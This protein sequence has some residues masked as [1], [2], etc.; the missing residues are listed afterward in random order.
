[1]SFA[2]RETSTYGGAPYE[3]YLFQAGPESWA[4]TSGD[5]AREHLGRTYLPLAIKRTAIEQN[6]ES[7]SGEIQVVLPRTQDLAQRFI[8][9]LPVAPVSLVIF[10]GHDG[11]PDVVVNFTG[12]VSSAEYTGDC[13]LHVS[14]EAGL[15]R[16]RIPTQRFQNQC[17]W[18]VYSPN[19]CGVDKAL[20]QVSATLTF[21]DGA[22]IKGPA[23][24]SKPNGWFD[25]GYIEVGLDRRMV[26]SHTGDTLVLIS[27][28]PGLSIGE[29]VTAYAGCS[30]LTTDCGPMFNNMPRFRGFDKIPVRN[31][32]DGGLI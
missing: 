19:G 11:D 6:Q 31:P 21:V 28:I 29:T 9:Y 13:V 27:G 14:T 15:L 22:T 8:A 7:R 18:C 10:R 4:Y 30:R 26:L 23:F 32:F 24:A 12:S 1:M 20:F 5:R 3:L 16:R 25:A 17:N 2:A